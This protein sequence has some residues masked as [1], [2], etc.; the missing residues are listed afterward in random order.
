MDFISEFLPKFF[1]SPIP[2]IILSEIIGSMIFEKGLSSYLKRPYSWKMVRAI[3]LMAIGVQTM[4]G[5]GGLKSL[6]YSRS[7]HHNPP[8]LTQRQP[9][10]VFTSEQ[11]HSALTLF[12]RQN[13]FL[14]FSR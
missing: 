3:F 7:Q 1:N 13:E 8:I 11:R 14:Q 4:L 12:F 5:I 10:S 6:N 2:S 9:S